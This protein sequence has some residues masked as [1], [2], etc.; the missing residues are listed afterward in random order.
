MMMEKEDLKLVV[1]I[2]LL[3]Q[4][5]P[6]FWVGPRFNFIYGSWLAC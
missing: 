4:G 2:I 3:V 6:P 5:Q 1:F